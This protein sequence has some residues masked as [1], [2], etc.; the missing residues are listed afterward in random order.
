MFLSS[1]LALSLQVHGFAERGRGG[2]RLDSGKEGGVDHTFEL[3]AGALLIGFTYH[4]GPFGSLG[5]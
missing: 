5:R 4:V 3:G 2:V 1:L